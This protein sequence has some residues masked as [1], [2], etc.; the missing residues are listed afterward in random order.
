MQMIDKR[1]FSHDKSGQKQRQNAKKILVKLSEN[2]GILPAALQI[3]GVT[4][5]CID[6]IN[7]GGFGDIFRASYGGEM[8]ALKCLR[9]FQVHEK[10]ELV[11]RVCFS[12]LPL[13]HYQLNSIPLE[14]L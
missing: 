12:L 5:R 8:V 11:H 14:I 9:N 2:C 3:S 4:N 13:P 6:P 7:G 10:R 1:G